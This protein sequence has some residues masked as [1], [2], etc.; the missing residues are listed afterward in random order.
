MKRIPNIIILIILL[1][2]SLFPI[3]WMIITSFK[4]NSELYSNV[5]PLIV[6]NITFNNY[7]KLI[8]DTSFINWLLNSLFV[9]IFSTIISVF[10]SSLNAYAIT[11]LDFRGKKFISLLIL[12]FYIIPSSILFITVYSFIYWAFDGIY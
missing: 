7:I 1:I 12:L 9:G 3:Y 8:K 5:S 11:R 4:S 10:F 6:K 2:I